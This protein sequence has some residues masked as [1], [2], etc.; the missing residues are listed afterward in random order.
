MKVSDIMTP[1][2]ACCTPETSLEEAARKMVENDCGA[3]PVVEDTPVRLIMGIVTDRDIVC[4]ILSQGENPLKLKVKHAMSAPVVTVRPDDGVD[5]CL[6]VMEANMVRRVP[7]IDDNGACVGIVTQAK[8]AKAT[9]RAKAGELLRVVS[10]RLETASRV[11]V[12]TPRGTTHR[13][14]LGMTRP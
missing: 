9:D 10:Q 14:I 3:I 11:P 2:P 6:S 5:D 4:R 13:V 7:V 12:D 1:D 8:I